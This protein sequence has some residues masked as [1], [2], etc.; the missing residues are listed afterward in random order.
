MN[1]SD[2]YLKED[3][4]A[5]R[6]EDVLAKVLALPITQWK[7]KAESSGIRHLGP[8]AQDFHAAF[9]LNG[10]DDTRINTVDEGGVALAAIQGLNQKLEAE[11]KGEDAEI[12][13]L[14]AKAAKVDPLEKQNDS[15]TARLNDLE[16]AL[17]MPAA[18]K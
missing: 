9:E 4:T 17:K 13:K 14:E 16:A 7:Y 12:A 6:P 2:R 1:S 8:V 11:A 18:K 5:V 3:F 15:L 10:G